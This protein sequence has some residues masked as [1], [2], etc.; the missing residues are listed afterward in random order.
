VAGQ[1]RRAR[2]TSRHIAST[3][4]TATTTEDDDDDGKTASGT[5]I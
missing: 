5:N 4:A 2:H 1:Q 3:T